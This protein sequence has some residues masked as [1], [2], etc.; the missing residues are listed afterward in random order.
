VFSDTLKDAVPCIPVMGNVFRWNG[1]FGY[2]VDFT[3]ELLEKLENGAFVS[4]RDK[5][6]I[7]TASDINY[8][9]AVKVTGR[10]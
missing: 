10:H 4:H 7:N 5:F 8:S 6:F 9:N 2:Q 3:K 1:G